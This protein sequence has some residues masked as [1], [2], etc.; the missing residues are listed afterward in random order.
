MFS[1]AER[2][3]AVDALGVL[4]T[5]PDER[6]DR[7]TRLARDVFDVPMVSISLLDHDRQ[8]RKSQV[9]LGG[10]EAPRKDSFCDLTVRRGEPVVIEDAA[11]DTQYAANP[12]VAGDPHLRFYA[13]CPIEAPGGEPVGTLCIVDTKPR[14]LDERQRVVLQELALWVQI[15]LAQ[16]DELDDAALIQRA[17]SPGHLPVIPGYTIAAGCRPAGSVAGDFYDLYSHGGELRIAVADVMGKGAGAAI[18]ASA[19]RASLRTSPDRSLATAIAEIDG[20]LEH[21]LSESSMFVT[22]FTAA[23]DAPSGRVR[24]I[25]AGHSLAFILHADGTWEPLHSTSL[26]LGMGTLLEP[27]EETE[28]VLA[29]GDALMCCSDGLLDILDP[30]DP[31]GNVQR[32]IAELGPV[33]AVDEAQR[34]AARMRAP[35]DVTV[36][37]VK[38]DQ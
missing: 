26:P 12:F 38:R 11:S 34:L 9:G 28:A 31:F 22:A 6:F 16:Q 19:V 23:L 4:D 8:W 24:F 10:W 37:V 7:I 3:R 30:E 17:L 25:D 35:D 18:I 13:G 33:G 14:L 36:I 5:P 15:E 20:L 21:D 2:Q 29:P 27:R 32:V 1:E